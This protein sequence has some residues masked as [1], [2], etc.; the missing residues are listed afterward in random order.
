VTV[1]DINRIEAESLKAEQTGQTR[2]LGLQGTQMGNNSNLAPGLMTIPPYRTSRP[3]CKHEAQAACS[4][5][6][7][8]RLSAKSRD[9]EALQEVKASGQTEES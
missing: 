4:R 3:R 1:D 8:V 2:G 9:T 7:L 6:R 5:R